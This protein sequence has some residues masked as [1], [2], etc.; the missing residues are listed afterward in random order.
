MEIRRSLR[1]SYLHN[2]IS[3]TGKMAIITL[4][5]GSEWLH[6]ARNCTPYLMIQIFLGTNIDPMHNGMI[7]GQHIPFKTKASA[8]KFIWVEAKL[9]DYRAASIRGFHYEEAPCSGQ[10]DCRWI[11]QASMFDST[12]ALIARFMELTWGP[13]GADRTQVGPM[14]ATWTLLSVFV[15]QAHRGEHHSMIYWALQQQGCIRGITTFN[16]A[17]IWY[18]ILCILDYIFYHPPIYRWVS[19][20]LTAE[21]IIKDI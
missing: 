17:V 21:C 12:A 19:N 1:P 14:L 8:D 4:N 2:G 7:L 15:Y 20:Y 16:S 5:R 11:F 6:K 18:T 9:E 10:W 13:S 3:Y